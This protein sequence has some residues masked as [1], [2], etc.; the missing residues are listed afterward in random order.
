MAKGSVS[1]MLPL[2]AAALARL[3]EGQWPR[4]SG[5]ILGTLNR[6]GCYKTERTGV[7]EFSH[8][9]TDE[10]VRLLEAYEAKH[11]PESRSPRTYLP[12]IVIF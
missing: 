5:R 12:V 10:G 6:W 3:A 1:K 8:Q 9:I 11:G 2:H 4:A 7:R